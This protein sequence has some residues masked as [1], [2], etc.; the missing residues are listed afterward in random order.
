[1]TSKILFK[2]WALL[3][4]ET[5]KKE[6][7]KEKTYLSSYKQPTKDHL[8]P[9]FG[10]MPLMDIKPFIVQRFFNLQAD[11]YY[12]SLVKKMKICLNGIFEKAIENDFC[13]K[14]PVKSAKAFSNLV[15]KPKRIYTKEEVEK[16]LEFSDGTPNG[17]YIRILLELGLR[18]SELCGLKWKDID[19]TEKSISIERACTN[20]KR[21]VVL[22]QVKNKKYSLT[23][24]SY[25]FY[26]SGRIRTIEAESNRFTV[27]PLWPLGNTPIYSA[28]IY[29][30]AISHAC[31][32]LS[33]TIVEND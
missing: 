27:C 5:Y 22:A 6:T 28:L 21:K 25:I 13:F 15:S 9:F 11:R 10:E 8:I 2:E 4:L 32:V 1:M 17:I 18:S 3:W 26:G 20:G 7:V 12:E 14:N 19:F 33:Q 31:Q 29:Y 16:I 24:L 23:P 30:T